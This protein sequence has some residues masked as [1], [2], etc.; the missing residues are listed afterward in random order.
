M[1]KYDF[2]D[3]KA[4]EEVLKMGFDDIFETFDYDKSGKL[5]SEEIANCFSIM[6][7]G[8]I[9]DKIFAAFNLFDINNTMTLDFDE[10]VKFIKNAFQI[11][12]Q[13]KN[14]LHNPACAS[15]WDQVD[16]KKLIL[17]T[18]EKCFSDCKVVKGKGE[19]NYTQFMQ[20]ITG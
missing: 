4:E 3:T 6:C 18:A 15:I 16:Y 1:K 10:L 17:A 11:F 20:W 9:N 19:I 13:Q 8:S 14:K 5:D 2:C 12:E 7:G